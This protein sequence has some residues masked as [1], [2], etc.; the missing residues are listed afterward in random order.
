MFSSISSINI[1]ELKIKLLASF[2]IP[3]ILFFILSPGVFFEISTTK[4]QAIHV[5]DYKTAAI[6]AF[7]FSLLLF[8]FSYFY[9]LKKIIVTL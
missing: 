8:C 9:L 1:W 4:T 2:L 3:F 5:I 6:H 7:I